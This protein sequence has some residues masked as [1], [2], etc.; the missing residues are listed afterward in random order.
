MIII[1]VATAL[2]LVIIGVLS[3]QLSNITNITNL[4]NFQQ[5][6]YYFLQY[7]PA[8]SVLGHALL[9]RYYSQLYPKEINYDPSRYEEYVSDMDLIGNAVYIGQTKDES[10]S[11]YLKQ[12]N[13]M[14]GNPCTYNQTVL[15][16]AQTTLTKCLTIYNKTF[17]NG[18]TTFLR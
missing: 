3:V 10:F 9:E 8:T 17:S 16:S 4:S 5:D 1:V 14:F 18:I 13:Y 15:L 7:Y 12:K 2:L 6:G 11:Y